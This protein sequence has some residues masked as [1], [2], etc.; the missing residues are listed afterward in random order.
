MSVIRES[1]ARRTETPNAVMTTLASPTLGGAE[2]SVWRVEMGPAAVGPPHA[3]D[4]QQVWTV[5]EGGATVEVGEASHDVAPGDTLV[6]PAEVLR[7]VTA[8]PAG[9][10]RALVVS[11]PGPSASVPGGATPTVPAWTV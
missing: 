2:H 1:E 9:G 5:L 8:D 3:F 7:R 4:V 11:A 10:L 6:L